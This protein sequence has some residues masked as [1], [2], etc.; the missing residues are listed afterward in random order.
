MKVCKNVLI[1]SQSVYKCVKMHWY[2]TKVCK[3]NKVTSGG[4]R[5][6]RRHLVVHPWEKKRVSAS[7]RVIPLFIWHFLH[8]DVHPWGKKRVPTSAR[9]IPLLS[10]HFSSTIFFIISAQ[11]FHNLQV[12]WKKK[13]HLCGLA[14][15]NSWKGHPSL[16]TSPGPN[17]PNDWHLRLRKEN[18]ALTESKWVAQSIRFNLIK[19][20][21]ISKIFV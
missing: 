13:P 17:D 8:L 16:K 2:S 9:V 21:T 1:L 7:T 4:R 15:M 19:I 11:S 6:L 10:W 20:L 14:L 12:K 5:A 18:C 3:S